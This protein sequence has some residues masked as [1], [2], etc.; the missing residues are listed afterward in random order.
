M[1]TC[2]MVCDI[3]KSVQEKTHRRIPRD[4]ALSV[5]TTCV[6]PFGISDSTQS[7][8]AMHSSLVYSYWYRS[9]LLWSFYLATMLGT[10]ELIARR[11]ITRLFACFPAHHLQTNLRCA[12]GIYLTNDKSVTQKKLEDRV[13][14]CIT[15]LNE[16]SVVLMH[17]TSDTTPIGILLIF[18]ITSTDPIENCILHLLVIQEFD[19]NFSISSRCMALRSKLRLN[20]WVCS[21]INRFCYWLVDS[22]LRLGIATK[23][24]SIGLSWWY[25]GY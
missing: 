5:W 18:W 7:S 11:L 25:G 22:R 2:N 4:F 24:T 19:N 9:W 14:C 16:Q 20:R 15:L 21:L 23:S 17:F 3:P 13:S 1:R 6:I 8:S 12:Q 10:L